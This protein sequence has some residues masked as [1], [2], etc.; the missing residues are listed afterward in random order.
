MLVVAKLS[1]FDVFVI[2]IFSELQNICFPDSEKSSSRKSVEKNLGQSCNNIRL[3]LMS[4]LYTLMYTALYT[5]M[6]ELYTRA[7]D[8]FEQ[9]AAAEAERD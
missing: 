7:S 8:S 5:L 4:E 3:T 6:S 1:L 2:I 9:A